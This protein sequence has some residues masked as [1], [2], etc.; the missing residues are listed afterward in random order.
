MVK[1][2]WKLVRVPAFF[3]Q[4]LS[5][6]KPENLCG[7]ELNSKAVEESKRQGLNVINETIQIFANEHSEKFDYVCAFQVLEHINDIRGFILS[8]LQVLKPGGKLIFA[9]PNNNPYL[10]KHDFYHPLNLP[11]HHAGLWDVA[12][13]SNLPNFFPIILKS[14]SVE[15]LTDYK[16][17][18][19]TQVNFLQ[20][21]GSMLSGIL[22]VVPRPVYKLSLKMLRHFIKGRNLLVEFE[23]K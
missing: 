4:M 22:S 20:E 3:L 5:S 16:K 23:K 6:K 13:F 1:A 14:L 9:V 2:S 21:K 7:L 10:Y 8:C 17:W 19:L 18:Y 15:P 11:P 12:T